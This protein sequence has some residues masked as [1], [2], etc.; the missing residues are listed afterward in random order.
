MGV[1]N[2]IIGGFVT[3]GCLMTSVFDG[4]FHDYEINLIEDMCGA[5]NEG[6]HMASILIM[7][8]WV[9]GLRVYQTTEIIKKLKGEDHIAWESEEPD[10]L[11]FTG[12]NLS[13]VFNKHIKGKEQG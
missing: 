9:Y 13:E 3:D 5:S 8:N 6:A 4:Y 11:K 2:V 1:K 10:Q 7:C 12:D